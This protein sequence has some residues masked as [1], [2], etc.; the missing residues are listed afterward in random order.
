MPLI[1]Q[2]RFNAL[3]VRIEGEAAIA[4]V[5]RARCFLV[6]ISGVPGRQEPDD[7]QEIDYRFVFAELQSL[8]YDGWIGCEYR[9][10]GSTLDGLGWAAP[11]GIRR[12]T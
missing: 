7:H 4:E 11:Y 12:P 5:Q 10:R 6:W 2:P 9:P 8:G 3:F 1:G